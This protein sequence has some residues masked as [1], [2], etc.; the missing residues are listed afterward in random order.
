M[1]FFEKY[2]SETFDIVEILKSSAQ[3]FI[4]VVYDKSTKKICVMKQRALHS[5]KIYQTLQELGDPRIPKI[6]RLIELDGK[7]IVV[8]E[9]I[10][11]ENLA[12]VATYRAQILNEKFLT[13]IFLSL[14]DCLNAVHAKKIIHRD[15]KPSNIML[16]ESRAVKV[17]DFGIA[18]LFKPESH[19]DTELL[20]TR[21]YAPPEQFGLFDF[22]QTD[23]RSDIYA[24]GITMKNLFG[25]NYHGR[26]KKIL[27]KCTALEP[28]QR[29]QSVEELRRAIF[30][31]RHA[32]KSLIIFFLLAFGLCVCFFINNPPVAQAPEVIGEENFL[33]HNDEFKLSLGSLK[34]GDS[35]ETM[36]KIFGR[37][38]RITPSDTPG[39]RHYEYKN[40]VVTVKENFIDA[41]VSYSDEI[42]TECGI[43]Q[44]ST[45]AEVIDAYGQRAAIY[46]DDGLTL[47]EY[48]YES[49]EG[50]LAIMRFAVKNNRVEYISLRLDN[51]DRKIL[52]DVKTF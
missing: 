15:L 43:H 48:P 21:G 26:L 27:D 44:D 47:Y 6:Y 3:D 17:I 30:F 39:H 37:E 41:L 52:Y 19:A 23:P 2:F 50:N 8:E 36:R 51:E 40:I 31:N 46:E 18:R 12:D 35:V 9:F 33:E 11:G 42:K 5:K 25:K 7:L 1:T 49:A 14:C 32:A 4:A 45:L 22:G 13:E 29:F 34:L 10:D 20:G 16:T 28:A 24:L 38:D